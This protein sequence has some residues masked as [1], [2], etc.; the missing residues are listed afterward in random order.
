MWSNRQAELPGCGRKSK[1][2]LVFDLDH[3]VDGG[4][5]EYWRRSMF[6][7]EESELDCGQLEF[8]V[9]PQ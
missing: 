9:G 7:R 8:Q 6:K 4:T 1:L 3:Q 5:R 2:I